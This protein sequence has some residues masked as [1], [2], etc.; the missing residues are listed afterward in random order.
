[1]TLKQVTVTKINLLPQSLYDRYVMETA[2]S[3][4]DVVKLSKDV[5]DV[6]K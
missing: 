3:L 5:L 6:M 1:M 4:V 2:W